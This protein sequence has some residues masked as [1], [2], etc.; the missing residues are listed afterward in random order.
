MQLSQ[1]AIDEFKEI[2]RKEYGK[3]ISDDEAR[4]MGTRLM[5]VLLVIQEVCGPDL[6]PGR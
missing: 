6:I 5:R 4:E 1:E 2:Y 3:E